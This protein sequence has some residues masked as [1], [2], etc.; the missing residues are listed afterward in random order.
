[1][2]NAADAGSTTR[3]G[4]PLGATGP[5]SYISNVSMR[6]FGST[7]EP[8]AG[9]LGRRTLD[10]ETPVMNRGEARTPYS[11]EQRTCWLSGFSVRY[12]G[13]WQQRKISHWLYQK[14]FVTAT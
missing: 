5:R 4:S 2:M 9:D 10:S 13:G 11:I 7:G 3:L 14:E 6:V 1:M 8:A 12:E